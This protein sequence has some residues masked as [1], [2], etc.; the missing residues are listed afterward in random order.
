MSDAKGKTAVLVMAMGGPSALEEVEPFLGRF[1]GDRLPSRE[2]IEE[3]K[4]RYRLIGGKSPLSGI[5]LRQ[6]RALEAELTGR[7][8]RLGVF[9][10]MRFSTPSVED[11]IAK[12]KVLGIQQVIALP[13]VPHRSRLTTEP[14]F[15]LLEQTIKSQKACLKVLRIPQWHTHPLFLQAVEEKVREGL[16]RF[17]SEFRTAVQV[18]FSVHSLPKEAV[19]DGPYLEEIHETIR[20][21]LERV[22]PFAWQLAF[23]SRGGGSES[24][25]EPDVG[26]VLVELSRQGCHEVLVV[27]LGFVSDHLETLYDL[28]IKYRKQ[29]KELGMEYQRSPSLNDSPKFIQVLTEVV[30]AELEK[31]KVRSG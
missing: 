28:D 10:G 1:L 12:M 3:I 21:L 11:A 2:R 30:L 6:A 4:G 26:E 23:Q 31:V 17:V 18:V 25:L 15:A 16:S 5:T 13:L 19:S 14:Y 7:G 8:Q 29:A 22:G 27:P 20:G 24:W 9:T